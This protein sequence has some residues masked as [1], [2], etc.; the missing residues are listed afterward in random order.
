LEIDSSRVDLWHARALVERA[1][2]A[3]AVGRDDEGARLYRSALSLWRGDPLC[4]LRGTWAERTRNGLRQ[5][6]L[7]ALTRCVAVELRLGRHE[8]LIRE[9]STELA[10]HPLDEVLAGQ[11]MLCLYRSHRHAEALA[12]FY[13]IKRELA[14]HLGLDPGPDLRRRYEEFLRN[15][16]SLDLRAVS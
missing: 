4:G 2:G 11:L 6:R 3:V 9:I 7:A 10:E 14:S 5:E 1:A 12:V 15:D 16:A 8:Q 13:R